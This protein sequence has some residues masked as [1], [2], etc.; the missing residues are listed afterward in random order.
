VVQARY[1]REGRGWNGGW[2]HHLVE[3]DVELSILEGEVSKGS[4]EEGALDYHCLRVGSAQF[5]CLGAKVR[6]PLEGG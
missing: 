3:Y 2:G 1:A 5:Q 4:P 6:Q